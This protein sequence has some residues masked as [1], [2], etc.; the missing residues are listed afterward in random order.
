MASADD[1]TR[2]RA[3]RR[4]SNAEA[5]FLRLQAMVKRVETALRSSG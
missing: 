3:M 2:E 4:Y 1:A 5:E